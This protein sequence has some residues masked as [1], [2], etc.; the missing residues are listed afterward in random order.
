[1][2]QIPSTTTT[3]PDAIHPKP[4]SKRAIRPSLAIQKAHTLNTPAPT[5]AKPTARVPIQPPAKSK[6][7]IIPFSPVSQPRQTT[8]QM[9]TTPQ[10]QTTIPTAPPKA[11]TTN[12][13]IPAAAEPTAL[14]NWTPTTTTRSDALY[15]MGPINPPFKNLPT[16][17]SKLKYAQ[18]QPIGTASLIKPADYV[19]VI[20]TVLDFGPDAKIPPPPEPTT[21]PPKTGILG[22]L[23][24]MGTSVFHKLDYAG[25]ALASFLGISDGRYEEYYEDAEAYEHDVAM[26][27]VGKEER[28]GA[29][30]LRDALDDL[31]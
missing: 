21:A 6:G 8:I 27:A 2:I 15:E 19:D 26:D 13:I 4:H 7:S 22:R 16:S 18:L 28:V 25:S 14:T 31:A 3:H 23:G 9:T 17:A 30:E 29:G 1:M 20:A 5:T 11:M 10:K 12:S 24:S